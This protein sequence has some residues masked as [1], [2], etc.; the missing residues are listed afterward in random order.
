MHS[1][2]VRKFARAEILR[3]TGIAH[4]PV[5]DARRIIQDELV[6]LFREPQGEGGERPIRQANDR[7]R[8]ARATP[9]LARNRSSTSTK[10]GDPVIDRRFIRAPKTEQVECDDPM[11][12]GKLLEANAH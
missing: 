4:A 10:P 5:V 12:G 7:A 8:C 3:S 9:R 2:A 1:N 6:D 11:R